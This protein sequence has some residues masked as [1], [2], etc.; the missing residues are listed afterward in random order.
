MKII[1]SFFLP[2]CQPLPFHCYDSFRW[3]DESRC[4][5]YRLIASSATVVKVDSER[6]DV[7]I[8]PSQSF[9]ADEIVINGK[10]NLTVANHPKPSAK[11]ESGEYAMFETAVQKVFI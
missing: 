10:P 7:I 1:E 4:I 9:A 5:G 6:H 8:L 3:D 2:K 11:N